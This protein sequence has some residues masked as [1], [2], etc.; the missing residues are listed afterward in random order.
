MTETRLAEL[1][2]ASHKALRRPDLDPRVRLL[3]SRILA[4]AQARVREMMG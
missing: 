1:I 4:R 2:M 3:V